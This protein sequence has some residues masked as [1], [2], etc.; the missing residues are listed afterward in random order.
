MLL[1]RCYLALQQQNNRPPVSILP[2]GLIVFLSG[3]RSRKNKKSK[4]SQRTCIPQYRR[5]QPFALSIQPRRIQA[6]I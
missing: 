3:K 5:N 1:D 2:V 6:C 4:A